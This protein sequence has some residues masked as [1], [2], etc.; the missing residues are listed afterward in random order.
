MTGEGV[1]FQSAHSTAFLYE[2]IYSCNVQIRPI[3]IQY[4]TRDSTHHVDRSRP[5]F[6][7]TAHVL[8]DPCGS[9][10][11]PDV[12]EDLVAQILLQSHSSPVIDRPER[13]HQA[14]IHAK[15]Q[16]ENRPEPTKSR[17]PGT[18]PSRAAAVCAAS[19]ASEAASAMPAAKRCPGHRPPNGRTGDVRTG[20][21]C[22]HRLTR[23]YVS[24]IPTSGS[25]I[26][27][28]NNVR[29]RVQTNPRPTAAELTSKMAS[30]SVIFRWPTGRMDSLGTGAFKSRAETGELTIIFPMTF[31]L[32]RV[33]RE[34]VP[35]GD[36]A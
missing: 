34:S 27:P 31:F 17:R 26:W 32:V 20:D 23:S 12:H 7:K 33:W 22:L 25:H 21:E 4:R 19:L 30:S 16:R 10:G 29:V 9:D 6:A 18:R 11:Q 3:T 5:A 36:S 35:G 24:G 15:K 2:F 28:L 13:S 8:D 1:P 14:G